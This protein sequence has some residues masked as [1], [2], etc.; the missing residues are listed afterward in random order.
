M[1]SEDNKKIIDAL[2]ETNKWWKGKF[3]LEFKDKEI[4]RKISKFL[5][6]RQIIA[7]TGLRRVGKTTIM[8]KIV[9]DYIKKGFDANR[10]I[11]FSYDY[12]RGVEIKE[13]MEVYSRLMNKDLDDGKYLFLFDEIQKLEHWEE[14]IKRIY[15]NHK[16][17]KIIVSGSESLFI[18]KKSKESLAGRC[19]EFQIYP[20]NFREFLKFKG[21]EIKNIELYREEILKAFNQY[22]LCGGFPETVDENEEFIK[23]YI[24][25]LMEKIIYKDIPQVFPVK[26]PEVLEEILNI[27]LLDPGQIINIDDLAGDL[28]ISRRTVSLYLNYLEKSFLIRKVYNFSRNTRKT[29]RKLK[30]YYP[31]IISSDLTKQENRG[32]I[33][34]ARMIISLDAEFFWRDTYKNEVDVVKMIDDKIVP[35]EIKYS[36]IETKPI[37]L[38]MKKFKVDEGIILTYDKE[39]EIDFNGKKIRAIPFYKYFLNEEVEYN[40]K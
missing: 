3:E 18:R 16:N 8:F 35:I 29:Q 1:L 20:L 15:D 9:E 7:L 10:V 38:F 6:A 34:E 24:K 26:S 17:F 36:R 39:K 2:E 14:Q 37:K 4:Y 27:I 22:L 5:D 21:M 40:K 25:N 12:F 13:I 19:F 33:F 31:M 11:Y 32:K 28:G 30:K 23:R